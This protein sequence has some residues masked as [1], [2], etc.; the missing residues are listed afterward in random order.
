M[1]LNKTHDFTVDKIGIKLGYNEDTVRTKGHGHAY[2][3]IVGLDTVGL[4]HDTSS[5]NLD[6]KIYP[7]LDK[8]C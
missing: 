1:L 7:N 2:N 8:T 4:V 5:P 6:S 3:D